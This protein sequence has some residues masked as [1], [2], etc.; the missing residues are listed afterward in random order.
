MVIQQDR[1]ET[2]CETIAQHDNGISLASRPNM[3]VES[4]C[5]NLVMD[6]FAYTEPAG[7]MSMAGQTLIV[8]PKETNR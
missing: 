2:I 4:T 5:V 8:L 7:H 6:I 3:K 1:K